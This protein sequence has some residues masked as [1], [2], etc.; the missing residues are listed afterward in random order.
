MQLG[1]ML[2]CIIF[3]LRTEGIDHVA[4]ADRA[5][6]TAAKAALSERGIAFEEQHHGIAESIYFHDPDGHE[7]EITTYEL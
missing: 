1:I 7:L 6:F 3:M 4:R 5:N 2:G